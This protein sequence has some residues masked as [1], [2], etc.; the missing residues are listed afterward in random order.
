M[1]ERTARAPPKQLCCTRDEGKL[2]N[3]EENRGYLRSYSDG[4]PSRSSP[5]L[6]TKSIDPV[7]W[8]PVR[9]LGRAPAASSSL[10]PGG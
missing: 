1:R 4:A 3:V 10:G 9:T 2:S 6:P 5:A 8:A 7:P